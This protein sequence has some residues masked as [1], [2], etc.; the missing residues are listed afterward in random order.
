MYNLFEDEDD[1]FQG[2]P[3]S[4]FMDIVYNANSDLVQMEFERLMERMAIMEM[5]LEEQYGEEGAEQKIHSYKYE[6][7]GDVDMMV[8]NLYIISVG[9]IVTRN[10]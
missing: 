8:K 5:M 7:S 2:S 9:N 3:K 4:K 10:E 6:R 1:V